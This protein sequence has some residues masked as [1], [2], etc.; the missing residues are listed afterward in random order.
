MRRPAALLYIILFVWCVA[1]VAI[2]ACGLVRSHEAVEA[3]LLEGVALFA[4]AEALGRG[5]R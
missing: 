3:A 4:A 5:G 2:I 1:W